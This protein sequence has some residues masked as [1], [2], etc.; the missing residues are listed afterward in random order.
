MYLYGR[1]LACQVISDLEES[2]MEARDP[3]FAIVLSFDGETA[4]ALTAG[5]DHV[6]DEVIPALA[7][8][9]VHGWWLADRENGRRMTVMVW[10][11]QEQYDAGMA[12]VQEARA[13][14]PDRHRPAPSSVSRFEVYGSIVAPR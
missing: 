1:N 9:G 11:T 13:K 4:D 6:T 3:M 12:R 5:I 14:N 10:D 8:S 2:N 7:E